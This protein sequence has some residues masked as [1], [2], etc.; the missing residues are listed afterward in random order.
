M[1]SFELLDSDDKVIQTMANDESGN[2]S[3]ATLVF[4]HQDAGKEYTYKIREVRG[5][6][7]EIVYDTHV[8][9]VVV[10]LQLVDEGTLKA[11]V[12]TDSDGIVFHNQTVRALEM[13]LTGREGLRDMVPGALTALVAGGTFVGRQATKKNKRRRRRR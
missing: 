11:T 8:E 3:F 5:T 13:P 7:E 9:E 2:V 10:S 4:D 12:K 6:D 1:F